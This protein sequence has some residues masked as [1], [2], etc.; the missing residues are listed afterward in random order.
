MFF[1]PF[2][3]SFV[4]T[5]SEGKPTYLYSPS[6]TEELILHRSDHVNDYCALSRDSAADGNANS[7]AAD[8]PEMWMC[9]AGGSGFGGYGGYGGYHRRIR[10]FE[11]DANEA[12]I[13]TWKRLEY[14]DTGTRLDEQ[15]LVDG[16]VVVAS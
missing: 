10:V 5:H 7:N 1:F 9:Y 11:L 8:K 6:E 16:G 15:V 4:R 2:L 14:G 13:T 12:R 3:F